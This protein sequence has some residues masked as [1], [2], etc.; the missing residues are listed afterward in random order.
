[1]KTT[2]GTSVLQ[3]RKKKTCCQGNEITEWFE[4]IN[5]SALSGTDETSEAISTCLAYTSFGPLR[6]ESHS[7]AR[8]QNPFK[9]SVTKENQLNVEKKPFKVLDFFTKEAFECVCRR[10]FRKIQNKSCLF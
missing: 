10:H 5:Y 8:T 3:L 7:K 2:R 9:R 6:L 4:V 1:V